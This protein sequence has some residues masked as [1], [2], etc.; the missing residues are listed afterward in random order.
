MPGAAPP[1]AP[2]DVGGSAMTVGGRPP[3]VCQPGAG[4]GMGCARTAGGGSGR[5]PGTLDTDG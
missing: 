1:R 2:G 5:G 3:G 4:R